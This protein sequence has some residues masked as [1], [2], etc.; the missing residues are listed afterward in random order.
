MP[1]SIV[2]SSL[3]ILLVVSTT[4]SSLAAQ[5]SQPDAHPPRIASGVTVGSLRYD[6][7]RTEDAASVVIAIR[8]ARGWSATIEPTFARATEPSGSGN[9]T[10]STSGL[11]DVPVS[12][13]WAH[14][15]GGLLAGSVELSFGAT[16]PVGDTATGFGTGALGTSY[17]VGG[18]I[19]PSEN[20]TLYAGAGHALSSVAA[21]SALNG[22]GSGWGDVGASYQA[23]SHVSLLADFSTD[24]GAVDSSYGRGR[25]VAAGLS[26]TVAGPFALNIE[27]SHGISGATPRWSA[28]IGIG[29]A[30]GSLDGARSLRTAFGGGRHGLSKSGSASSIS[31][32]RGRP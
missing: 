14:P 9:G 8:P 29:T 7:G 31:R 24:L 21:Q 32:G 15:F 16:L 6:G 4:A 1:A 26:Y 30:F 3:A 27:T 10:A 17:G 12:L 19:S 25:S 2:H 28:I 23:G 22:G 13:A 11:T 5:D 20:V 18:D